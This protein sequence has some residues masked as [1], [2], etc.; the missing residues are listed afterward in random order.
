MCPAECELNALKFQ[1]WIYDKKN[2]KRLSV[3][4]KDAKTV[5]R[6]NDEIARKRRELMPNGGKLDPYAA[7]YLKRN[8]L[9]MYVYGHV[10]FFVGVL[11][12]CQSSTYYQSIPIIAIVLKVAKFYW[13]HIMRSA[14]REDM[15]TIPLLST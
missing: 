8:H 11:A 15:L 4:G 3:K 13:A 9:S 12:F 2:R 10:F 14:L 6:I 1:E 5:E 7:L